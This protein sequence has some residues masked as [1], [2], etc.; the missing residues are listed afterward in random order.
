MRGGHLW[1][2]ERR[3]GSIVLREETILQSLYTSGKRAP[4]IMTSGNRKG[5]TRGKGRSRSSSREGRARSKIFAE[6]KGVLCA[7]EKEV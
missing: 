6:K 7:W 1:T 3:K 4:V 5:A 2:E